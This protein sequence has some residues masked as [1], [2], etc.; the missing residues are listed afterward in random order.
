MHAG[1]TGDGIEATRLEMKAWKIT[2]NHI[3]TCM[4][5]ERMK[6]DPLALPF[7]CL[8]TVSRLPAS[9]ADWDY[10]CYACILYIL[11]ILISMYICMYASLKY[12]GGTVGGTHGSGCNRR[13][14][15]IEK[16]LIGTTDRRARI[17]DL[18]IA[19]SLDSWEPRQPV[20]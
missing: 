13:G 16:V 14:K 20:L 9:P 7:C 19:W 15:K 8:C 12:Q 2:C 11:Y 5:I 3:I 6:V 18:L 4:H 17:E 1:M 10:I